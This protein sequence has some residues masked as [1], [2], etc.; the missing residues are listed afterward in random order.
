MN[1]CRIDINIA[2]C[3][4]CT[5]PD[6]SCRSTVNINNTSRTCRGN[7]IRNKVAI[8]RIQVNESPRA[9]R[10]TEDYVSA[11]RRQ[12]DAAAGVNTCNREDIIRNIIRAWSVS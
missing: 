1:R 8:R 9:H 10:T 6:I 4:Q 5:Q 7:D 2:A 12:A 3:I 11:R